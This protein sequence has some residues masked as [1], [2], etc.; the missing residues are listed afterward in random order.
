MKITFKQLF[1]FK[2][3]TERN[4]MMKFNRPT[5]NRKQ[6]ISFREGCHVATI[7]QA[8][9]DQTKDGKPKIKILVVGSEGESGL[10]HLTFGNEY[11]EINFNYLLSSI[12]D[13]GVDI[14]D[15]DFDY[16]QE[17][18]EFLKGKEVYIEVCEEEYNGEIY[19]RV[20]GFLRQEDFDELQS[21]LDE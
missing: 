6:F 9:L 18:T 7:K 11:T 21:E 20:A 4:W 19:G 12:E 17:T 2:F 16:N 14:P 10:Y 1:E 5:G 13:N 15:I 3:D 8:I